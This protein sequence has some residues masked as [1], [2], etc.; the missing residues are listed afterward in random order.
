MSWYPK[1]PVEKFPYVVA[2]ALT[3]PIL[4]VTRKVIPPLSGVNVTPVV[5]FGLMSLLNEILDGP[6][7]L[8]VLL[9][10]QLNNRFRLCN[11]ES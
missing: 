3:K 10:Q 9:S 2:Y 5:W 1:L 7:G 8:F 4:T 11:N 6:Q